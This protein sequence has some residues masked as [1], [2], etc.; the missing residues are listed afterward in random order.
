MNASSFVAL[1][2]T[3]ATAVASTTAPE[4]RIT[5]LVEQALPGV[6]GKRFAAAVVTFPPGARAA[7]HRHGSAFLYVYVLE[8]AV[9]S[10][11]EGHAPQVY[12][13]GES[14]TEQPG[15]HHLL[16]ENLSSSAPARLLVTFVSAEGAPLKVQDPQ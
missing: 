7:P 16:T 9:R 5:P 14:W 13:V 12:R 8:G 3:G 1:L 6:A 15:V 4:E 11:L 10:Q 2:L